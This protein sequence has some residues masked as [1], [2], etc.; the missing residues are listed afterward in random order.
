MTAV[1]IL[2]VLYC[3]I[4]AIA[5]LLTLSEAS[6]SR[7]ATPMGTLLGCLLCLAWLPTMLVFFATARLKARPRREARDLSP[8]V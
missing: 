1:T 3:A 8:G 6:G 4:A 2:A 5:I 7:D